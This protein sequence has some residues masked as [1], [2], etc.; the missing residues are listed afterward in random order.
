MQFQVPQFIER[1]LK[2]AGPLTFK[3]FLLIG[4]GGLVVILL[5][6]VLSQKSFLLFI[7]FTCLIVVASLSLAFVKI[8]GRDLPVVLANFFFFLFSRKTYLWKKKAVSPKII[9]PVRKIEQKP[10]E[11]PALK[12]SEKSKLQSLATKLEVGMR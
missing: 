8:Q 4:G 7:L 10:K 5:Y 11:K 3:Q 6:L 1:E 2:I 9:T 12:I